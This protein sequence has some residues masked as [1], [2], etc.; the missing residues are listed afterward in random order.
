MASLIW[1]ELIQ[2]QLTRYQ[3]L[4]MYMI[5]IISEIDSYDNGMI[6]INRSWASL[7]VMRYT[8]LERAMGSTRSHP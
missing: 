6:A 3:Y 4:I 5:N 7:E 8:M 1:E 2:W